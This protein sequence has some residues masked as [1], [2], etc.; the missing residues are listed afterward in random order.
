MVIRA[1]DGWIWMDGLDNQTKKIRKN[2]ERVFPFLPKW[3]VLFHHKLFFFN[4][5]PVIF[6]FVKFSVI[7]LKGSTLIIFNTFAFWA[8]KNM[9]AKKKEKKMVENER[10]TLN[11]ISS[12]SSSGSPDRS[13]LRRCTRRCRRMLLC[14]EN[15]RPQPSS[16]H[17]KGRSPVCE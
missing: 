9:H 4:S 13:R 11:Y 2:T 17:L 3:H 10:Y 7:A 16:L 15:W 6:K 8:W 5:S 14:T 1:V 12:S